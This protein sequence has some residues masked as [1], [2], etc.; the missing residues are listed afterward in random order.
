MT[1]IGRELSAT[2]LAYLA[3][4]FACSCSCAWLE[5]VVAVSTAAFFRRSFNPSAAVKVV[6]VTSWRTKQK[7][8]RF[9]TIKCQ[10]AY[11]WSGRPCTNL[12][13]A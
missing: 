13:D 3:F 8:E 11:E 9:T 10:R 7:S 2:C 12:N 1:Q 4:A 5:L 6:L